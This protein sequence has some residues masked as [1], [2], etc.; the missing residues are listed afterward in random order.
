M[1]FYIIQ[2]IVLI[3]LLGCKTD[4]HNENIITNHLE[5]SSKECIDRIMEQDSIL[6]EIRNNAPKS[7]SLS[8]S[9]SDYTNNSKALNFAHCPEEFKTSYEKHIEAWQDF[10]KVTD[11]YAS[12]RGELH[13]IFAMIEKSKDSVEYKHH[14]NQIIASWEL[15][16]EESK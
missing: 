11:Q 16:V 6:G 1:K 5:Y 9:I 14:L 2:F 3:F 7:I 13:E 12:L 8:E 4:S 15:V 10:I